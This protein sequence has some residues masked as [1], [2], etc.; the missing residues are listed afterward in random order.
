MRSPEHLALLEELD[1]GGT[2]V[3]VAGGFAVA[4]EPR[5]I[6]L[7]DVPDPSSA[8][9]A[10]LLKVAPHSTGIEGAGEP[11]GRFAEAWSVAT[12]KQFREVGGVRLYRLTEL[13]PPRAVGTPRL[14]EAADVPACAEW[15]DE[16][17][18]AEDERRGWVPGDRAADL[19]AAVHK[20]IEAHRLWLLEV[21]GEPVTLGAHR[22]ALRGVVRLGPIYTPATH[23]RHGY[24]TAMTAHLAQLF[25]PQT[26]VCLRTDLGNPDSHRVYQRLGFT[27]VTDLRRFTAD[28]PHHPSAPI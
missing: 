12:G 25:H 9:V 7:G 23:R 17:G 22:P 3:E 1:Q 16:M 18:R 2:L 13:R 5:G 27:P 8:L 19:A 11:A 21:D 24:G 26:Q 20:L 14:A 10:A 15:L 6:R 28:P 4:R